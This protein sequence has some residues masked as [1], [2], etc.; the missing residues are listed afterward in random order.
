M[1]RPARIGGHTLEAKRIAEAVRQSPDKFS[2]AQFNIAR[3]IL[4]W[5][6]RDPAVIRRDAEI[7]VA[8]EG[9]HDLAVEN[10]LI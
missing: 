5:A 10:G 1:N 8:L 4:F 7:Q 3:R 2:V 9:M 6:E